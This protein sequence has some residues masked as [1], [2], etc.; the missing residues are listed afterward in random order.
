MT[1]NYTAA[2]GP[3]TLPTIPG[4][5]HHLETPTL[6]VTVYDTSTPMVAIEPGAV[7]VDLTPYEVTLTFAQLQSGLVVLCGY[8]GTGGTPNV[9]LPLTGTTTTSVP[10]GLHGLDTAGPWWRAYGARTPRRGGHTWSRHARTRPRMTLLSP[11]RSPRPE[12]SSSMAPRG[13]PWGRPPPALARTVIRQR[14]ACSRPFRVWQPLSAPITAIPLLAQQQVRIAGLQH[15]LD[16]AHLLVGLYDAESPR[17]TLE[18]ES[19]A[20]D[21]ATQDILIAFAAPQ[22]GLVVAQCWLAS[23]GHD[24]QLCD[25]V[26][27]DLQRHHSWHLASPSDADAPGCGL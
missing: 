13:W 23:A 10:V 26:W 19:L 24:R 20:V 7:T 11:L 17:H 6:L 8:T 18:A 15:G 16:T 25:D 5:L 21:P 27:G 14:R 12:R 4:T 9:V 22:D 3:T 2:F 1:G